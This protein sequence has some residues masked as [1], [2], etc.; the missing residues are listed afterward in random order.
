MFWI[1]A[2][3]ITAIAALWLT[4]SLWRAKPIDAVGA[5]SEVSIYRDQLKELESDIARGLLS[6]A[7]AEASRLEVQRRLLRA[8][9]TEQSTPASS[10]SQPIV[11]FG[12][13]CVLGACSFAV[14]AY[15]GAPDYPDQP[16][17]AR[18]DAAMAAMQ[19]RAAQDDAEKQFG[20]PA[21]EADADQLALLAQL[22]DV[23]D[24]G[25]GNEEGFRLYVSQNLRIGQYREAHQM[26]ARL[27]AL[28]GDS[29]KGSDF[30]D[31]AEYMV[32]AA[33]GYVS[34]EAEDS[35]VSALKL[36]PRNPK[37]RYFSGL[38]AFQ[39]GRPDYTFKLWQALERE[40]HPESYWMQDIKERLPIVASLSGDRYEPPLPGPSQ[41]Q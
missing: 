33:G 7:D 28:L 10:A 14:Y 23:L 38:M 41:E 21:A 9:D 4:R 13:A 12:L 34:P 15:L 3:L 5:E 39:N 25:R 18:L 36:E 2:F 20:L 37:A 19:N 16:R 1:T 29:A 22:K 11:A 17:Q 40:A 6:E 26:Q 31:L 30:A 8:A 35:L 32:F 24:S 27:V